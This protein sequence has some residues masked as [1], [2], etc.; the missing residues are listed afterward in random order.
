ME[1]IAD[2]LPERITAHAVRRFRPCAHCEGIGSDEL[3]IH[4]SRDHDAGLRF[5]TACYVKR[6]GFTAVLDLPR[7]EQ[8]KFRLCD[9]T[10][11]QMRKLIDTMATYKP[12]TAKLD[13]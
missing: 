10:T 4:G 8:E 11:K 12:A 13:K 7:A 2:N 1:A 9:L 3:M 5:H 6:Y